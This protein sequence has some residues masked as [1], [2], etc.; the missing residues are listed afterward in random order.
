[1]DVTET[2]INYA[3]H[4]GTSQIYAL[5]WDEP[6]LQPRGIVQ[7][8]HGA[9][10][11]CE[12]YRHFARFLVGEGFVVCANDHI[13]HGKSVHDKA[14][15]GHM[16][17]KGGKEALVADVDE[18]RRRI[19]DRYPDVPYIMLGHS[20]G[21][22]ILRIYL[23]QHGDGLG[24]A[25]LSGTGQQPKALSSFGHITALLIAKIKGE[26]YRSTFLHNLGMGAL[27]KTIPN[28]RT[29]FDWISTDPAVVDAYVKDD[30]CGMMFS[31]GGYATL[32]D[33][34]GEMVTEASAKAVPDG[35]PLLF[36][37]GSEDP[38]GEKGKAVKAAVEQYRRA[39]LKNVSL[40]LYDGLR[41]EILNEPV[42]E[43]VYRDVVEWLETWLKA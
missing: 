25:V 1:M 28:A 37:S 17:A 26:N 11:Y 8:V 40:R 43:Q 30:A 21:S 4:D 2:I 42:R 34:T 27:A 9:S 3:S 41:H 36:M 19:S 10:E 35:L 31:V 5:L 38:V 22:F 39:G 12:R 33:I 20:M 15:L 23:T 24:A 7:I 18:L 29:P 32:T 16:P 14:D 6:N 13:G